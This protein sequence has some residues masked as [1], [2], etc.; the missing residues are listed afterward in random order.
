MCHFVRDGDDSG[1]LEELLKNSKIN[2]A[3]SKV[4]IVSPTYNL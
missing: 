1:I 3:K 4:E 2:Q